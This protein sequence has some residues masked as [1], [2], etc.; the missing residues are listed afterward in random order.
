[1]ES[2][3]CA[4]GGGGRK[5]EPSPHAVQ[6]VLDDD[7]LLD[8]NGNEEAGLNQVVFVQWWA[9]RHL[10]VGSSLMTASRGETGTLWGSRNARVI[11]KFLLI[12]QITKVSD[13]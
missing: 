7:V 13:A 3:S 4:A 9:L 11:D 8:G 10:K 1:M 2:L 5:K 12:C 6:Q